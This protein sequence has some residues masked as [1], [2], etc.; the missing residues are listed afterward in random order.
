MIKRRGTLCTIVALVFVACTT[1]QTQVGLLASTTTLDQ[2]GQQFL[3]LSKVY[4]A[5]CK[6]ATTTIFVKFCDGFKQYA[7]QFQKSYHPAVEALNAANAANDMAKASGAQ[8]T[9]LQLSV[10]LTAI[11]V[12][13]IAATAQK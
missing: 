8:A 12:E 9:I 5:N 3:G 13:V 11:A 7:P 10:S 6:P 1:G 4:D 2:L